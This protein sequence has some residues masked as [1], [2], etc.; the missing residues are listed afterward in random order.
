MASSTFPSSHAARVLTLA[1]SMKSHFSL[2]DCFVIPNGG[3][4]RSLGDR[5]GAAGA[6]ALRKFLKSGDTLAVTGGRTVMAVGDNLKIAGLQ[7]VTVVQAIGGAI[8]RNLRR[9]AVRVDDR[10]GNQRDVRQLSAPAIASTSRPDKSWSPN[11]LSPSSWTSSC[12]PTRRCSGSPPC[13]RTRPST[14]TASSTAPRFR[15]TSTATP[16][17]CSRRA[18]STPGDSRSPERSTIA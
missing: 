6:L 4:D 7:D 12:A 9:R 11:R 15:A 3:D 10:R 8:A 16:S 2:R 17:A 13:G 5:L 18:S 14:V 1:Q